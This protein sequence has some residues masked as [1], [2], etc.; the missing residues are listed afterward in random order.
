VIAG[1]FKAAREAMRPLIQGDER[2]TARMCLLMAEI[3]EAEHGE[4]G[5]VREW[6]ARASRAPRD[7][8]WI[9]DGVMSDQW[10]PASPVTGKLD[11]FVWRRPEDRSSASSEPAEAVFRPVSAPADSAVLIEKMQ[12]RAI[13][14]PETESQAAR[15]SKSAAAGASPQAAGEGAAVERPAP[16]VIAEGQ[17]TAAASPAAGHELAAEAKEKPQGLHQLP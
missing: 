1:D 17:A 6:L 5:Y 15:E 9:A 11:A 4:S 12:T 16:E 3:E 10:L 13:P 14:P 2:P 8:C 7:A